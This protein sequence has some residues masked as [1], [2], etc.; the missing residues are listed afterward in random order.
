MTAE[1]DAGEAKGGGLWNGDRLGREEDAAFIRKFLERRIAERGEA[2]KKRS[3]VL[4]LDA[5]W[6]H[7]KT[8]FL[9]HF[10]AQASKEGHV[11]AYVNA[12]RDDFS[13][14]PLVSVMG[15]IDAAVAPHIT[16]KGGLAQ[17]YQTVKENFGGILLAAGMGFAG[18]VAR[19]VV[20]EAAGQIAGMVGDPTNAAQAERGEKSTIDA[21]VSEAGESAIREISD[22]MAKRAISDFA[23]ARR[24][25]NAFREGLEALLTTLAAKEHIPMPL[26]VLVDELDRCR[27]PFAI[28]MLERVKHLFDADNVV[29]IVATDTEQLAHSIQSVYG[30]GFGAG[31][32]LNRFFDRTYRFDPPSMLPFVEG[33]L[34][35]GPIA[36]EHLFLFDDNIPKFIADTFSY[37]GVSLRDAEQAY[38]LVRT[39]ATT[40]THKVPLELGALL[41]I[42]IAQIR[43]I[44]PKFGKEVMEELQRKRPRGWKE[45]PG[46]GFTRRVRQGGSFDIAEI[47]VTPH[48]LFVNYGDLASIP[49]PKVSEHTSSGV[50][51]FVQ[52]RLER[53]F[54]VLHNGTHYSGREPFSLVAQ[55]PDMIRKAGRLVV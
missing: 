13:D 55:Y 9:E 36:E 42:A 10:A 37:F 14:D 29:F 35:A 8:F 48:D 21:A 7:G 22:R 50:R 4:N 3:Y 53:E 49:L 5:G 46:V 33:L 26:Y 45:P 30:A 38:D 20:G 12:W 32:Y 27:P 6:G 40:W 11:V 31:T 2:G 39:V 47:R 23:A 43:A 41:P 52:N 44:E 51:Q 24:S 18:Q 54:A 15:A 16:K 34:A 25:V 17:T 28:A 19:K 1:I